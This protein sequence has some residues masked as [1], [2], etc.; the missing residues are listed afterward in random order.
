MSL[1][2]VANPITRSGQVF[3]GFLPIEFKFKREDLAVIDTESGTGGTKINIGT[4]LVSYLNV[5]DP[6]YLYSE[7]TNYI[8]NLVGTVLEVNAG[9]ITIDVPFYEVSTGG[10]K[11]LQKLLC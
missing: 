10:Y 6:V 8:Y 9:D 3:S 5:G 2:V 7:A 4:S 11:L 1:S